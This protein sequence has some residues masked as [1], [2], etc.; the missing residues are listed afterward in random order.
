MKRFAALICGYGVPEDMATDPNYQAYLHPVVNFLFERYRDA[1]GKI[2]VNGGATDLFRPYRRTEAGEMKKWLS[3][4]IDKMRRPEVFI[5]WGIVEKP[6]SLTTVENLLNFDEAIRAGS[7]DPAYTADL[8]IFCEATRAAR[9]RRLVRGIPKL[10]HARVIPID[11]D[12]SPRRY[13]LAAI[14]KNERDFLRLELAAIHDP[15][16]LKSLRKMAQEKLRL[17]RRYTPEEAHRRL[18][19]ILN[20]LNQKYKKPAPGA[21]S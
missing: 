6:R 18:P 10:H 12:T 11:F 15:T 3:A 7:R 8:L 13:D 21:G 14:K 5:N 19:E 4:Q 9:I 17:M 1:E 20:R 2:I 16:R